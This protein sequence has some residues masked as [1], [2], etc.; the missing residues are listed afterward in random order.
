[1]PVYLYCYIFLFSFF[2]SYFSCSFY[3][4]SILHILFWFIFFQLVI[5]SKKNTQK[6]IK[7]SYLFTKFLNNC[8]A[9]P[10]RARYKVFRLEH[11][12][13]VLEWFVCVSAVMWWIK[14]RVLTR[15]IRCNQQQQQNTSLI[16][17]PIYVLAHE[18]YIQFNPCTNY[19]VTEQKRRNIW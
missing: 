4:P 17:F 15:L 2:P 1:M 16:P 7:T 5:F 12:H 18:A 9:K 11:I 8:K 19:Q 14:S 6:T 3:L 13:F 10:S